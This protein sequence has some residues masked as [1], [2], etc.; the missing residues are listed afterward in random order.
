MDNQ[1]KAY[2]P[3][4]FTDNTGIYEREEKEKGGTSVQM[5]QVT[6]ILLSEEARQQLIV[7]LTNAQSPIKLEVGVT[8]RM[9]KA[10]KSFLSSFVRSITGKAK[11]GAHAADASAG[12]SSGQPKRQFVP[13]TRTA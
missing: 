4:I 1:N 9:G 11:P 3:K 8:E 12:A 13:K 5:Y 6:S 2:V 10:G 7:Q